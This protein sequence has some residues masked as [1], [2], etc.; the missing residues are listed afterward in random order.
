MIKMEKPWRNMTEKDIQK[1][2][3]KDC[4]KCTYYYKGS[5]VTKGCCNYLE[6]EGRSRP[7]RPGT[8]REQGVFKS[9][10]QGEE[11]RWIVSEYAC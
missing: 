9:K 7:C 8:C 2:K 1:I 4:N 11:K 5:G 3:D 10:N 6:L